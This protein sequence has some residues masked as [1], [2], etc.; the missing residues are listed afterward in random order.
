MPNN[1][2]YLFKPIKIS[3]PNPP[4]KRK[5][6]KTIIIENPGQRGWVNG[7][8]SDGHWPSFFKVFFFFFFSH[9]MDCLKPSFPIKMIVYKII[10]VKSLG[11]YIGNYYH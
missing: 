10:M 6:K 5:K 3:L 7:I 9:K 1:H 11:T 2:K 8:I 4:N